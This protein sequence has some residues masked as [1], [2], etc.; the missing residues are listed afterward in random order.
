MSVEFNNGFI[1]ALTLFYAHRFYNLSV[2][3]TIYKVSGRDLRLWSGSDHLLDI[4][5]PDNIDPDLRRRIEDFVNKVVSLRF[6]EL[7]EGEVDKV[8]D[9][10]LEILKEVDRRLFG[11]EVTVNYP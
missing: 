7:N 2:F 4:Q 6:A 11:L 1:T 5:I 9:E 3:R 10:C 8:F